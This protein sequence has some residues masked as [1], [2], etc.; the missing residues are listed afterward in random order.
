MV[1]Q[2]F[3]GAILS[4]QYGINGK[5]NYYFDVIQEHAIT[6]T[7]QI[8]DNWM[9]NNTVINDHIANAPT[10]IS[11]RGLSG[12]VVYSSSLSVNTLVDKGLSASKLGVLTQLYP[13][14]D[15]FLQRAKNKISKIENTVSRYLKIIDGLISPETQIRLKQVYKNLN[16][17]RETKTALKVETP[18]ANFENMYIQS[19]TL[20]QGNLDYITDIELTLK[21]VYFTDSQ[22]TTADKNV[23]SD[24]LKAQKAAIENHG[25]VQGVSDTTILKSMTNKYGI[26]PKG[27]GIKR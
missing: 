6:L 12:E 22:T 21:Q 17:L 2:L 13:P 9:E 26:T 25:N 23:V 16:E 20:R 7:S 24:I 8:T 4:L 11:L 10:V 15:N 1:Q 14:A 18:Y 5:A 19:L 3:R 27:S